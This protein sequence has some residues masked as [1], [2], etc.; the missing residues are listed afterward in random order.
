MP[1]YCDACLTFIT[2][3]DSLTWNHTPVV[4]ANGHTRDRSV[5]P[6]LRCG[7]PEVRPVQTFMTFA[8][9]S[10]KG[11]RAAVVLR[12]WVVA[13]SYGVIAGR[14]SKRLY[15]LCALPQLLALKTD[16]IPVLRYGNPLSSVHAP[17]APKK[18]PRRCRERIFHSSS[19]FHSLSIRFFVPSS[20]NISPG[21]GRVNPSDAH[22]RVASIPI[23]E[24]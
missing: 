2:S 10:V 6:H 21:H 23:F 24:P 14:Q 11:F 20:I 13:G 15:R 5:H 16:F 17:R 18:F 7:I 12:I 19:F 22:F 8:V 3:R 9:P 1:R 4:V